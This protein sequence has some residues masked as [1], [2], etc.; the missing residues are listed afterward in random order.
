M[1]AKVLLADVDK[2]DLVSSFATVQELESLSGVKDSDKDVSLLSATEVNVAEIEKV[3]AF[4]TIIPARFLKAEHAEADQVKVYFDLENYPF[5]QR[6]KQVI[7]QEEERKGVFRY[8]RTV[9]RKENLISLAE[10]LIVLTNL[11]GQAEKIS[12]KQTDQEIIP[13]HT[14]ITINFGGGT[15]AHIEYTVSDHERIELE[16]SGVKNIIEFDSHEMS[17]IQ[18]L[19]HTKLPLL[20]TVDSVIENAHVADKEL[21]ALFTHY[22]SYVNGGGGE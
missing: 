2:L 19:K 7:E 12:I 14:I 16:W 15:M 18:P 11:F 13:A 17:P 22:V 10:D 9:S 1:M 21:L 6:A 3:A 4:E 5:Y 20:Y 8:R